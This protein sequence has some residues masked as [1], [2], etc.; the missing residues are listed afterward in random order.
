MAGLFTLMADVAPVKKR[1]R[2]VAAA[3]RERR[4]ANSLAAWHRK[5]DGLVVLSLVLNEIDLR[6]ALV[7]AGRL[8]PLSS[9]SRAVLQ[10]AL[11]EAIRD[12]I[13]VDGIGFP[14]ASVDPT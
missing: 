7:A 3:E 11:T 8:H 5:S 10:A 9:D 13:S 1:R 4:R 6:E 14:A 2:R 12:L